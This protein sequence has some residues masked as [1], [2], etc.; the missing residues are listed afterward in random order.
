MEEVL[1]ETVPN[2]KEL[3]NVVTKIIQANELFFGL[4]VWIHL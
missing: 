3:G 4:T 1:E 2:A